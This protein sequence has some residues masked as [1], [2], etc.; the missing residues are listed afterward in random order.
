MAD[1]K[2]DN[3]RS[4]TEMAMI[5][6]LLVAG[7]FCWLMWTR[8]PHPIIYTM[9]ALDWIQIKFVELFWGLAEGGRGSIYKDYIEAVFA[10]RVD[11]MSVE[12]GTLTTISSGVGLQTRFPVLILFLGVAALVML[13]MK[14]GKYRT[15]YSLAGG[16]DRKRP[17]FL[18]YQSQAWPVTAPS[19]DFSPENAG[20]NEQPPKMPLYWMRANQIDI[21]NGVF[22]E[23]KAADA[24]ARQLG[25]TW[26]DIASAKIH[27]QAVAAICVASIRDIKGDKAAKLRG[28]LAR[29]W[30]SD[31]KNAE[32]RTRKLIAR[33][34][35]PKTGDA[36]KTVTA[37]H[38]Y[39][40]TAIVGLLTYTRKRSGVLAS[41]EM[42]WIKKVDRFLWY[43]LNNTGRRAF[44]VEAAGIFSHFQ[45]EHVKKG[46]LIEPWTKNAIDGLNH[47]IQVNGITDL[48]RFFR[49]VEEVAIFE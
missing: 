47:Y 26:V 35:T 20:P 18:H 8:F 37:N 49:E 1:P 17:S 34:L 48:E 32:G 11:I 42:L 43:A 36:S 14:G 44:M 10:G 28:D 13:K 21:K 31:P 9:F 22:D 6:G 16:M 24:F 25:T 19:V 30:T 29:I 40:N 38:A 3:S 45:A 7:I 2:Q 23:A 5:A 39:T 12:W 33:I 46:K 41:A 4:Q 27:V 15:V